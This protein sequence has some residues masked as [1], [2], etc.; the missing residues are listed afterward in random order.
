[1]KK[2]FILICLSFFLTGCS[3]IPKINFDTPNTVPQSIDK[4]K[5]KSI[6]KGKAKF[7][8]QGDMIYCSKGYYSYSEGYQKKERKMTIIE[9]IKSF[10]NNLVGWSFWIFVA[11]I[12][13]CPSLLGM[14]IGRI[15]EA[16]IG[17]SGKALRS[18]ITAIQK[19]RK[20]GKPIDDA[21]SS[22]Q[23]KDVKNY[24]EKIKKEEKLK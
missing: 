4:S 12:I 7:N 23:D 1:M 24:V 6:C 16:T 17:I 20:Q 22:E 21:L 11:L 5:A 19:V 9:R 2:I 14:I 3:L 18:T 10:I 15:L 13:L 8:E